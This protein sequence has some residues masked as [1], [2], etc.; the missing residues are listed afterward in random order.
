MREKLEKASFIFIKKLNIFVALW[1]NYFI[2][3]NV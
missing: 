1:W 2:I 3:I